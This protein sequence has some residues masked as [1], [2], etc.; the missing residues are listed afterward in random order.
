MLEVP[1]VWWGGGG[2]S[3]IYAYYT[4]YRCLVFGL[5]LERYSLY[6]VCVFEDSLYSES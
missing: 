3:F 1:I 4:I 6:N 2:S 5:L